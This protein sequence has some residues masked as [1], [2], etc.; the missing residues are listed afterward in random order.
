MLFLFTTSYYLKAMVS[1]PL[2]SP[3][4]EQLIMHLSETEK[5]NLSLLIQAFVARPKR[6]MANVMDD[7]AEYAKAQGLTSNTL[8]DLLNDA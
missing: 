2:L 3:E 5:K 8:N 4:T 7:M 6:T 1:L